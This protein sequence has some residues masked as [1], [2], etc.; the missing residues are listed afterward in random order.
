MEHLVSNFLDRAFR[1]TLRTYLNGCL[2]TS[3]EERCPALV[4]Y[5]HRGFCTSMFISWMANEIGILI[6]SCS[7]DNTLPALD[8]Q[9]VGPEENERMSSNLA[10]HFP[11][12]V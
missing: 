5:G 7:Q 3:N 2:N 6:I 4:F 10:G 9:E 12:V 1:S 11:L 8:G